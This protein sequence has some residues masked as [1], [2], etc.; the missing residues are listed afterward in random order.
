MAEQAITIDYWTSD[1]NETYYALTRHFITKEGILR[2]LSL[3][4]IKHTGSSKAAD[5]VVSIEKKCADQKI[6]PSAV[7]T[8]CEPSMV[9]AGRDY[10][11]QHGG[12]CI[13]HRLEIVT[14]NSGLNTNRDSYLNT[15]I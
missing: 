1:A 11:S 15:I 13:D 9:A 6:V 12:C 5:I 10:S 7:I 8:D 4:C 2:C 14:G 3:D